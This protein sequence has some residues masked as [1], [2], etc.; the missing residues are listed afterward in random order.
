MRTEQSFEA[1]IRWHSWG[2]RHREETILV[3]PR[4]TTSSCPSISRHFRMVQS[5]DADPEKMCALSLDQ[6][7]DFTDSS[8]PLISLSSSPSFDH[9]RTILSIPPLMNLSPCGEYLT[10]NTQLWPVSMAGTICRPVSGFQRLTVP[11]SDPLATSLPLGDQ[12]RHL[13]TPLCPSHGSPIML[14]SFMF[15]CRILLSAPPLTTAVLSGDTAIK[16]TAFPS[17]IQGFPIGSPSRDHCRIEPSTD[18]LI[19]LQPVLTQARSHIYPE[20]PSMMQSGVKLVAGCSGLGF[21]QPVV[22]LLWL[23]K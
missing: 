7:N 23:T 19:M 3:W 20:W 2:H 6:C 13:T 11:S 17:L 14:A 16:P 15:H 22:W 1:L 21:F 8:C 18:A 9:T 10:A 5:D 12:S 4:N